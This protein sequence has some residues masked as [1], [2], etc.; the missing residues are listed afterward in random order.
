MVTAVDANETASS[1]WKQHPYAV[2]GPLPA[3]VEGLI[4]VGEGSRGQPP[5]GCAAADW[6]Q[7]PDWVFLG[8]F[9]TDAE[10]G[11]G[12]GYYFLARMAVPAPDSGRTRVS[13]C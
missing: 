1:R 13:G 11:Y 5:K 9:I 12:R 3:P 6:I 10:S 8:D 7:P 4:R 2:H